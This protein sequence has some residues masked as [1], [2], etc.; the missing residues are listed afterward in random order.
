[1]LKSA[2]NWSKIIGATFSAK[3]S[4]AGHPLRPGK[5][6]ALNVVAAPDANGAAMLD[7][8]TSV[9]VATGATL[10]AK[11]VAK[12]VRGL[13]VDCSA[14][15]GTLTGIDFAP[16]GTLDLVNAPDGVAELAVPA[17]LGG[18]SAES[19]ANLNAYSVTMNGRRSSRWGVEVSADQIRV[20]LRG[21]RIVIR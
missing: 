12:T 19:L 15:V 16:G 2:G 7:N 13:A 6:L 3:K 1:M 5:G 11:G 20:S 10:A 8:V 18:V 9:Q 4:G 14:G 17:G 21:T